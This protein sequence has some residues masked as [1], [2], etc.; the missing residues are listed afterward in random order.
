MRNPRE[1]WEGVIKEYCNNRFNGASG[2]ALPTGIL[3]AID[4]LIAVD[5]NREAGVSAKT[6]NGI[7]T[8]SYTAEA[9]PEEVKMLLRPY[10]KLRF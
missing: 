2:D 8:I 6:S 3:L 1:A 5:A 4:K 9:M 10:R 7:L